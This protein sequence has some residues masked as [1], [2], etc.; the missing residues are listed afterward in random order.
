M[1]DALH[2]SD[3]DYGEL[4]LAK[5]VDDLHLPN[6]SSI[7]CIDT[8][9]G[10]ETYPRTKIRISKLRQSEILRTRLAWNEVS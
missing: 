9:K 3:L 10:T 6:G 5:L 8:Q 7:S 1:R 4:W 2:R